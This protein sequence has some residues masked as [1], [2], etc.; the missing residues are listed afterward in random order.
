MEILEIEKQNAIIA[1]RKADEKGKTL[2]EN[3]FG[4]ELFSQKLIDRIK[5]MD[6]VYYE[7]GIIKEKFEN[8]FMFPEDLDAAKIR[9]IIKVFNEGWEP[10]WT[11]SSEY[12]YFTWFDLSSGSGFSDSL[13]GLWNSHSF[14][15]S[16]LCFKTKELALEVP[17]IFQKE[18][19]NYITI[20]K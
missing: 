13:Y 4:K 14:V 8:G 3:L 5:N 12:K 17:K 10:D 6:D 15:G 11:N 20:K 18:F 7:L 19:I 16:R 9:L 2:L 1:H